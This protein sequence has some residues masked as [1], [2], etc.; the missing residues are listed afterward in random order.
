MLWLLC[1]N[2]ICMP[3]LGSIF[4]GTP[5]NIVLEPSAGREGEECLFSRVFDGCFERGFEMEL[6]LNGAVM[7]CEGAMESSY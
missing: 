5:F 7:R 2:S 6:R 4:H 1:H 3:R